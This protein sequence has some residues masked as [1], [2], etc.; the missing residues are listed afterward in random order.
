[1]EGWADAIR[2]LPVDEIPPSLLEHPPDFSDARLDMVP[3]TPV[4]APL[5][6]PW[7]PLPPAQSPAPLEAPVCPRSTWEMLLPETVER[8]NRW[9]RLMASD[10]ANIREHQG[11]PNVGES[12]KGKDADVLRAYADSNW[13]ET[14]S[15]TGFCIMLAGGAIAHSSKRQHCITLSSCEA[16]LIA[17]CDTAVE[18]IY[19][20]GLVE[21]IG[22]KVTGSV[23][24]S[25]DN[26]GAY[27]L[28][29]RF[30][31]AQH[32]RHV[33]RKMFKMRELRGAGTVVVKHIPTEVTPADMFTK[34]LTRQ[35][36]ER[37]ARFVMNWAA[38]ERPP[39]ERIAQDKNETKKT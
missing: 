30:T 37:H 36:F 9:L 5:V 22:H 17:L 12:N 4:P 33:D 18:L 24:V 34:V 8:L 19:I 31:S 38:D 26:K 27:D 32:S 23:E 39:D 28:C 1:M 2:L 35:V 21:F 14:R 16:E 13:S 6:L 25:T 10:L 29:H 20:I 7:L 11:E 15:T 3:F